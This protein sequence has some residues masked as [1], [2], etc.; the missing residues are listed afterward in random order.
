MFAT[1]QATLDLQYTQRGN[2]EYASI[3]TLFSYQPVSLHAKQPKHSDGKKS[4][5]NQG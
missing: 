4:E 2:V 5:T 1:Q 3:W